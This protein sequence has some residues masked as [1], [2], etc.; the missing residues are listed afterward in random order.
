[1]YNEKK[2]EKAMRSI[3]RLI[4]FMFF[5]VVILGIF[6]FSIIVSKGYNLYIE[7]I[8]EVS[9]EE[10]IKS[11]K[12]NENYISYNE[13]PKQ[14]INAIVSIEDRRFFKHKGVDIQSIL[15][16]MISNIENEDIVEGG[17]TITQQLSKNMYFTQEKKFTRKVAELFLSLELE[18]NY[19]KEDIIEMYLNIIYFGDGYYGIYEASTGYFN[20]KPKE[21]DL[22][23]ITL[24]AGLPNA[25][26]A[27]ALSNETELSKQRQQMVIEAMYESNYLTEEEYHKLK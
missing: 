16:A 3:F 13:I 9:I 26:S 27:Y 5:M 21:L 25:P 15:R 22:N 23:E 7:K 2:G 24:L 17:S 10:K 8:N 18:K 6:V 1:M 12:N 11:I 20:K 4:K 19:S 14:F